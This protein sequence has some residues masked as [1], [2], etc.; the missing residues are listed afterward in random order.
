MSEPPNGITPELIRS[1]VPPYC[2]SQDLLAATITSIAPPE[3][4]A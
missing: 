3:P 1:V 4:V 2:L